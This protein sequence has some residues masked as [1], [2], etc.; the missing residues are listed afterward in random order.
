MRVSD[1]S[2]EKELKKQGEEL[3]KIAVESRLGAKQLRT[4]YTLIKTKPLAFVEAFI[5]HQLSRVSGTK[6]LEA[7]LELLRKYEGDKGSFQKIVMYANMLY[8]YYER[9]VAM[10]YNPLVEEI[11]KKICEQQRCKFLGLE[12]STER[13]RIEIM[14]KVSDYRGDPKSLAYSIGQQILH[15]DPKFPGRIWI[16]KMDRR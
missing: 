16:E 15:R 10:K 3:A 12:L 5:Q 8:D 4:I 9:Q 7:A 14:V 1:L 11:A 13:D 6:A 2:E